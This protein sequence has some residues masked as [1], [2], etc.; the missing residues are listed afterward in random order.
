MRHAKKGKKFSRHKDARKALVRI[1]VKQLI[2]HGRILTTVSKAKVIRE[3]VEPMVTRAKKGTLHDRRMV[4]REINEPKLIKKLFDEIGPVFKERNG[5]YTRIIKYSFRKGDNAP[6][7]YIEF[8]DMEKIYKKEETK[9]ANKG[10][11]IKKEKPAKEAKAP[12]PSKDA[13]KKEVKKE[14]K[15]EVKK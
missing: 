8:V 10:E 13:G 9:E 11:K 5:G 3:F 12:K 15:K 2:Q 14:D 1:L 6:T 7:A 4:A